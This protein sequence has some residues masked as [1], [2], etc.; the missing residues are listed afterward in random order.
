MMVAII[1]RNMQSFL[2]DEDDGNGD[3]GSDDDDLSDSDSNS[4]ADSH[5]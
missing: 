2:T 3:I 5:G 4:D 1:V